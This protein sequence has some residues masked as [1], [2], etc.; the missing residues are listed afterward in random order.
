MTIGYKDFFPEIV[1]AGFFTN[2]H[3]SMSATVARANVWLTTSDLTVITIETVVLPNIS[4]ETGASQ[5]SIRTSGE[6]SSFWHQVVR[7]W[8]EVPGASA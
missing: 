3:E 1:K 5:S 2:D 8:Y 7:V 6:I 4:S